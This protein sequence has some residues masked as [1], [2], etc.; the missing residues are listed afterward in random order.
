MLGTTGSIFDDSSAIHVMCRIINY[1]HTL[2]IM[3]E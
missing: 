2:Q 1:I 3:V